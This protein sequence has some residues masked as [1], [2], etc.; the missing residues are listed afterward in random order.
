MS[1]EF[2]SQ[3]VER[4]A[5][6]IE[7]V[8]L[9]E[10]ETRK[11]CYCVWRLIHSILTNYTICTSGSTVCTT[12]TS[13]TSVTDMTLYILLISFTIVSMATD[14]STCISFNPTQSCPALPPPMSLLLSPVLPPAFSST[15][16]P[17]PSPT[18]SSSPS[19][20]P[21]VFPLTTQAPY[22]NQ[23]T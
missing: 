16:F 3:L 18:T 21:P 10:E 13:S 22:Y 15:S 9:K 17:Y 14:V 23:L 6:H 7:K 20:F 19:V 5:P 4:E 2:Q 1:H 12:I 8:G 11:R